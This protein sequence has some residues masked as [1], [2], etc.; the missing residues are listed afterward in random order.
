MKRLVALFSA[1]VMAATPMLANARGLIRDAEIEHALRAYADPIL[2]QADIPAEDVRLLIVSDP[3]INAFVAGGLNIFVHT[4]LIRT[5]VKPGMLIGVI[6]HETG[7]IAGAHLSQLREKSTRSMLGSVIGALLGA[8]AVAGGAGQAGAGILI[9]SQT[10]ATRTLNTGIRINEQSAD[11]AALSYLD[12]LDISASGMLE[13]FEAMRRQE[14]GRNVQQ[15]TFMRTHPLTTERITAMRNH[16]NDSPIPKGQ[17]PARFKEMHARMQAKLAGFLEPYDVV[18]NQYPASNTSTAAR[19]ARAIAAFKR[20][21]LPEALAGMDKLIA[22]NPNDPF[23]YDTKGQMLF[24]NGRLE[25]ATEAYA[26]A[27]KRLPN[28]ALILTDYAKCL[29]AQEKP[30]LLP[31]AIALLERAK[32]LDDSNS[33]TWRELAIAY[34]RQGKLGPSYLALAEEAAVTGKYKEVLQHAARAR[35]YGGDDP[36]LDLK[37]DD[38]ERDAR[39]QLKQQNRRDLF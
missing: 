31:K 27:Q 9:G 15:D 25:E 7:H 28:S 26:Q 30:A 24:E 34:G 1:C 14:Q 18:M 22:E 4:G 35:S 21:R 33:A 2:A 36:S 11:Q 38:L 6:A 19:Y 16:I 12:G 23:F 37:L 39:M 17:V 10:A 13:M 5:A 8:A 32:E 3:S 20:N 29:T